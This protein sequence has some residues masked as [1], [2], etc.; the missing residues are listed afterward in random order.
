MIRADIPYQNSASG[1][2]SPA[3]RDILRSRTIFDLVKYV[4]N[5]IDLNFD[6]DRMVDGH[7]AEVG[8]ELT[9]W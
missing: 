4:R 1:G 8:R 7:V 5:R 9:A 2:A 3:R 6:L